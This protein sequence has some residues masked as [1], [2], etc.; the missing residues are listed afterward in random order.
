MKIDSKM[1][2]IIALFLIS[3]S[4]NMLAL[5]WANTISSV[6][7]DGQEMLF[8][9]SFLQ[10]WGMFLGQS[11]CMAAFLIYKLYRRRM[12][13]DNVDQAIVKPASDV[14]DIGDQAVDKPA[15][16]VWEKLKLICSIILLAI[17]NDFA[18]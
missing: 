5:K 2:R 13:S 11:L 8:Q 4:I 12:L 17:G 3:G 15:A 16:D 9:T 18:T 6:G 10:V 1:I 14:L 7:N